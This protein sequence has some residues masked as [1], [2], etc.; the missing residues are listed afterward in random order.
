[1]YSRFAACRRAIR[2]TLS[3]PPS[4][5]LSL[6]LWQRYRRPSHQRD[7]NERIGRGRAR[8]QSRADERIGRIK[9]V[10]RDR[11]ASARGSRSRSGSKQCR[12]RRHGKA[13]NRVQRVNAAIALADRPINVRQSVPDINHA[14]ND[15]NISASARGIYDAE[16]SHGRLSSR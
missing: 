1:L 2:E 4:L 9:V 12:G 6:S 15:M 3:P 10:S 8:L 11:V 16:L 13:G 14:C 5:S 7:G